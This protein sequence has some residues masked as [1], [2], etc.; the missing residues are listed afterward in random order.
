MP[1][2][3]GGHRGAREEAAAAELRSARASLDLAER[4]AA[5]DVVRAREDLAAARLAVEASRAARDAA[6]EGRDLMRRRFQE[7]LASAADLLDAESRTAAMQ[8]RFVE[9]LAGYHMAR[10]RLDYVSAPGEEE[11]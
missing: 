8:S 3:A 11:R 7:G 10:A 5:V 6:E 2:F 9:A 4:D 1:V